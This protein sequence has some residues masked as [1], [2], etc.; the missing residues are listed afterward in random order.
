MAHG[1][2]RARNL[3]KKASKMPAKA[4]ARPPLEEMSSSFLNTGERSPPPARPKKPT[5]P[6]GSDDGSVCSGQPRECVPPSVSSKGN[7]DSEFPSLPKTP[8]HSAKVCDPQTLHTAPS[9]NIQVEIPLAEAFV[10]SATDLDPECTPGG[11]RKIVYV[12]PD[13]RR[14][15]AWVHPNDVALPYPD[16]DEVAA[17]LYS[18]NSDTMPVEQDQRNYK[19]VSGLRFLSGI[20]PWIFGEDLGAGSGGRVRKCKHEVTGRYGAVKIIPKAVPEYCNYDRIVDGHEP[21]NRTS[22]HSFIR[23]VAIMK[24]LNAH[25]NVVRVKDVWQDSL[26]L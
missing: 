17:G 21:L 12:N 26:S 20:G 23:E 6:P 14:F 7:G 5:P 18:L 11:Q 22:P 2:Q 13:E 24:L 8:T 4:P 19:I 25:P 9:N 16:E 15:R 1:K 3:R 10:D